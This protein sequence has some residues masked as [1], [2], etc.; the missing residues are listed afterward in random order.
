MHSRQAVCRADTDPCGGTPRSYAAMPNIQQPRRT[1]REPESAL[2]WL[3]L[4]AC[5]RVT[6][7]RR[8]AG[9]WSVVVA[10]LPAFQDDF[11]R[12][13]RPM[14]AGPY[15]GMSALPGERVEWKLAD[16]LGIRAVTT[17]RPAVGG[18]YI[19]RPSTAIL[20]VHLVHSVMDG[21]SAHSD[22]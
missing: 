13:P 11:G 17:G 16:R 21:Q 5:V 18:G 4:I 7:T 22:R 3:R 12:R 1:H 20:A 8:Q 2:R 6:G 14:P 19:A 15:V 10:E 9:H